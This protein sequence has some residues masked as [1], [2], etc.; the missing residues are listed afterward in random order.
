MTRVGIHDF[1]IRDLIKPESHR[2]KTILSAIINF[3]KFREEQLPVFDKYT[4]RSETYETKH[5]ELVDQAESNK[6]RLASLRI[7]REEEA[8]LIAERKG[9]NEELRNDLKN[10]KRQQS[11]LT[12][13]IDA[14]KRE[15]NVLTEKLVRPTFCMTNGRQTMNMCYK[16]PSKRSLEPGLVSLPLPKNSNSPS[17]KCHPPSC[18]KSRLSP[19][20]P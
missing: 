6:A 9:I 5:R 17:P 8:P 12:N 3:A 16:T 20:S 10:L 14:L 1:S 7:Q 4:E 18:P 19:P 11:G 13:E 15:K 2:V